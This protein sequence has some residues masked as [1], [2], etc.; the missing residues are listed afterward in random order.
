MPELNHGRVVSEQVIGGGEEQ[1]AQAHLKASGWREGAA[2][3]KNG[4]KI[5]E[6]L[7]HGPEG[8]SSGVRGLILFPCWSDTIQF[9]F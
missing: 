4:R 8:L 9:A 1:V 5:K 2:S 3:L 6:R 7:Q